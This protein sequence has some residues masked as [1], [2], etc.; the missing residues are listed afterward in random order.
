MDLSERLNIKGY[1]V[2]TDIQKAFDSVN[3]SFLLAVFKAFGFGKDFY[4]GLK[5]CSLIKSLVFWMVAQI[6]NSSS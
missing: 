6:R 4:I 2:T 5:Y 1:L 3:H